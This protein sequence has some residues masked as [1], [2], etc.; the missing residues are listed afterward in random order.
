[1]VRTRSRNRNYVKIAKDS[2]TSSKL[3]TL[4]RFPNLTHA[5]STL[6]N[7]SNGITVLQGRY[8]FMHYFNI[9]N[10]SINTTYCTLY[11]VYSCR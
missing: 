3:D 5:D 1:M 4:F 10:C 6:T 9:A 7:Y 11:F 8:V 2:S